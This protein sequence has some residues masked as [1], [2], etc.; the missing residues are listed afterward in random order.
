MVREPAALISAF[1]AMRAV[2][3]TRIRTPLEDVELP[4]AAPGRGE[5]AVEIRASGIC[6]SDVHY[7][8]EAGRARLPLIPGHE[9]AGVI[10]AVGPE[11]RGLA[12][13]D[14]VAIHYL[15]ENGEMIGKDRD[16][17]YAES[18]LVPA[19]NAVLVP[20]EVPFEQAAV[21]M[22]STATAWHA[23]RLSDLRRG[24]SLGILGFGGLGISA[25]Q[26]ARL[27]EAGRLVVVEVIEQK[28]RLAQE[29][30]ATAVDGRRGDLSGSLQGLDVV[31]DFAGHGPTTLTAMRALAP[32]GRLVFVDINLRDFQF[33]PYSD[34]LT[35]E[36]RLIGSSDHTRDELVELME[37]AR[38]GRLD[39]STA[40]T[41]T[42]PLAAAAINEVLDD[43]ERG[44]PH[45]RT[46]IRP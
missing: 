45:L 17:G 34:L 36:R 20:G 13:G 21:M 9:I 32:G 39:L 24:E 38:S 28:L 1:A 16:G 4:A 2:R 41:R 40:I 37:L 43:L 22:C 42:V 29:W 8:A 31:L 5:I 18:I 44:T 19:E 35:H 11:V 46:V 12:P 15:L 23:L 3:L 25:V 10:S 30:G 26:L 27:L 7:R 33:D 14:R 6:H